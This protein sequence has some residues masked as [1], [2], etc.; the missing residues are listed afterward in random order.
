V[1]QPLPFSYTEV[2]GQRL[3]VETRREDVRSKKEVS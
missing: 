3:E 2:E 1:M